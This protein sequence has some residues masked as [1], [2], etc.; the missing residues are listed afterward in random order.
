M[1]AYRKLLACIA[2]GAVA[3]EDVAMQ[4]NSRF[5][6]RRLSEEDFEEKDMVLATVENFESFKQSFERAYDS[7]EEEASRSDNFK[8]TLREV[9]ALNS[10]NGAA[11]FGIT[12]AADFSEE[13]L[14]SAFMSG[15]VLND[16]DWADMSLLSVAPAH[17]PRGRRLKELPPALNWARTKAVTAIKTQGSCGACWAFSAAETIES[18]YVLYGTDENQ[19]VFSPQQI[20]SCAKGSGCG[21]GNPVQAFNYLM[22]S[23]APGLVQE[24]FL[25]IYARP[26]AKNSVQWQAMYRIM[27]FPRRF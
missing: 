23:T 3:A 8:A 24:V 27:S 16:A 25:A 15:F 7:A 19:Q 9:D 11:V 22:N 2:A 5:L 20:A 17:A 10:K 18:M 21:G 4:A 6:G 13:E 26:Y 12:Y 14:A 1:A